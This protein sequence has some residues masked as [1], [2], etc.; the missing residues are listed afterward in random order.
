MTID[1]H[2]VAL[3]ALTGTAL[4][5]LGALYLSYDLLGGRHGPLRTLTRAVTYGILFFL[6]YVI[7]LPARFSAIAAL[8]IGVTLA[9]EFSRAARGI[10]P[11]P[12]AD[13]SFSA[14]R[15]ACYGLGVTLLFGWR[16]GVAFALLTTAGQIAA[17]RM[18]FTPVLGLEARQ[19][20][21]KHLLGVANRTVGYAA[22]GL[23]SGLVAQRQNYDALLFGIGAGVAIGGISALMGVICPAVERWAD[24]LPARRLGLFGAFLL[25]CGFVLDSVEHWLAVFDVPIH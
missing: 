4:N 14:I 23:L 12:R 6:G 13:A 18:G 19:H 5:L 2:T 16:F 9:I 24:Q 21:R 8:G 25:C 22:A 20:M 15:G 17:Y 1:H 11:S 3:I 10:D 7:V